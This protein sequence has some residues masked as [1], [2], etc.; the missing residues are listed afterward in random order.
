MASEIEMIMY[1]RR[2]N[3]LTKTLILLSVIIPVTVLA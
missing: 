1:E 3:A 2:I